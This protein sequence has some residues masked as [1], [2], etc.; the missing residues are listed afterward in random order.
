LRTRDFEEQ[1]VGPDVL[2]QQSQEHR[3]PSESTIGST[4]KLRAIERA[5][6][7]WVEQ[8]TPPGPVLAAPVGRG[9]GSP[10]V[11]CPFRCT[12]I[13]SGAGSRDEAAS[14]VCRAG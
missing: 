2:E 5:L 4:T 11:L 7:D 13:Y 14:Y 10:P 1:F 3:R 12:A 6:E 8:R 9:S